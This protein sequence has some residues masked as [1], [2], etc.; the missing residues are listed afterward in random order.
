MSTCLRGGT[1]FLSAAAPDRGRVRILCTLLRIPQELRIAV[2]P[3]SRGRCRTLRHAIRACRQLADESG[4]LACAVRGIPPAVSVSEPNP[5]QAS[6]AFPLTWSISRH[7]DASRK[8]YRRAPHRDAS[9]VHHMVVGSDSE[10]GV[11]LQHRRQDRYQD[12]R[13]PNSPSIQLNPVPRRG[14][15][16]PD[17][18]PSFIFCAI[19]DTYVPAYARQQQP[20]D[21]TR[22]SA[23]HGSRMLS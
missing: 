1:A 13:E 18:T 3:C 23:E 4:P 9:A 7:G 8:P 6:T 19:P 21:V 5:P 11:D 22:T 20:L 14:P 2:P 12:D 16:C 17:L 10:L 15:R